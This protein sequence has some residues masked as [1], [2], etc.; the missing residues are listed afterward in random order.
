MATKKIGN[1]QVYTGKAYNV[2]YANKIYV[3]IAT[4]FDG[5]WVCCDCYTIA[6]FAAKKSIK[7]LGSEL[8]GLCTSIQASLF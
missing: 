7:K 2:E 5:D 1:T 3:G 4:S 8:F 6:Q